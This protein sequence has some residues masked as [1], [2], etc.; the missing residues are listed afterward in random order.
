[1]QQLGTYSVIE[2]S[3]GC[4]CS[5]PSS[6]SKGGSFCL[7]VADRRHSMQWLQTAIMHMHGLC[8]QHACRVHQAG[9]K[10]ME[11]TCIPQ[12]PR[13][14]IGTCQVTPGVCYRYVYKD[15]GRG[16]HAS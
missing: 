7:A 10:L 2:Q 13:H 9:N 6:Q 11:T 15:T 14:C 12:K 5:M 3:L 8:L 16:A 1:M 4:A